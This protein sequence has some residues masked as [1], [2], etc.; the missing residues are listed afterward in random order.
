M[1]LIWTD[2]LATGLRQ[3]DLQHQELIEL[4]NALELAHDAGQRQEAIEEILP[5]LRAYV[6]FHFGTEEALMPTADG[7]HAERHRRQHREF[8]ERITQLGQMSPESIDLPALIDYLKHWL[9]EHI[10]KTDRD[11][12]RL[13]QGRGR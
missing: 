11:L 4:I 3:I 5:R 2:T 13:I 6:M 12:V 9:I 7:M 1:P 8:S 10:M